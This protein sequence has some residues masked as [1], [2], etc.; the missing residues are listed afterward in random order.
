MTQP[1]ETD[2]QYLNVI[3]V[4]LNN[5]MLAKVVTAIIRDEFIQV[6]R[7]CAYFVIISI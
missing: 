5:L 6:L 7:P 4:G 1:I 2:H 3:T